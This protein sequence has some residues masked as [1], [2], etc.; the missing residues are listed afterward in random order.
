ML[1]YRQADDLAIGCINTDAIQK[2]LVRFFGAKD[3]IDLRDEDI[4][5]SFNGV[6]V[7]Q[8]VRYFETTCESSIEK[9]LANYGWSV[10]GSRDTDSKPT[11]SLAT[12][13]LSQ[14]L[15]DNDAVPREGTDEAAHLANDAN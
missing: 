5:S 11:E 6:E 15:A 13:T 12:L 14:M 7:E 1:I 3:G 9:V 10:M 4:I 2:D 8:I